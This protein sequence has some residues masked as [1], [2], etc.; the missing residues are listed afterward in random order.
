MEWPLFGHFEGIGT[1]ELLGE[2]RVF[3]IANNKEPVIGIE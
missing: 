3:T 2:S 1:N